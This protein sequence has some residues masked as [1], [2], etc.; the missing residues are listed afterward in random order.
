LDPDSD[1]TE[2][3]RRRFQLVSLADII[4][5]PGERSHVAHRRN[6]SARPAAARDR[7]GLGQGGGRTCWAVILF[8]LWWL[9]MWDG[10]RERLQLR[11]VQ[12]REGEAAMKIVL[13]VVGILALIGLLVVTGILKLIF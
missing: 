5:S 13:W 4:E 2:N 7:A 1:A 11:P 8:F 9:R 3:T 6:R 10:R 12:R